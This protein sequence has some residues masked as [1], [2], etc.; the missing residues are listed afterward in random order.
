MDYRKPF[1]RNSTEHPFNRPKIVKVGSARKRKFLRGFRKFGMIPSTGERTTMEKQLI[2]RLQKALDG[3]LEGE[4]TIENAPVQM[5]ADE[6][7]LYVSEQVEKAATDPKDVRKLR[8]S[9]LKKAIDASFAG[10]TPQP[11]GYSVMRF[12]D[13]G[14]VKTTEKVVS[15]DLSASPV[16]AFSGAIPD[17][18]ASA[19][20]TLSGGVVPPVVAPGSGFDT[21][22]NATFAKDLTKSIE[23]L[24]ELLKEDASALP[25]EE[26]A[27]VEEEPEAKADDAEE[28]AEEV[29]VVVQAPIAEPVVEAKPV[30]PAEEAKARDR[31]LWPVDM[32]TPSGR[33]EVKNDHPS[34]GYDDEPVNVDDASAAE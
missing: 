1:D 32:N 14:Q 15:A 3:L 13:P 24:A 20:H 17:A 8:L 31:D 18:A 2:T 33:G 22:D 34:W 5:T 16:T 29:T 21:P 19:D 6:F 26:P 10:K 25:I 12:Q 27:V 11:S 30:D 9:E 4:E 7:V 28:V 23:K